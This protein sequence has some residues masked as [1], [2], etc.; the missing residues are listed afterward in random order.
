MNF[1]MIY[2]SGTQATLDQVQVMQQDWSA[3]GVKATLK[4]VNYNTF[5][6]DINIE[7]QTPGNCR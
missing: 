3:I 1:T 5:L 2:V 4:G 7:H 6:S